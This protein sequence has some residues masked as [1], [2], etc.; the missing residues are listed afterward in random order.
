MSSARPLRTDYSAAVLRRLAKRAKDNSQSRRLLSPN[1]CWPS[2]S[3]GLR[4]GCSRACRPRGIATPRRGI[5][6]HLR[7]LA[8]AALLTMRAESG[9]TAAQ[10]GS[11]SKSRI[12]VTNLRCSGQNRDFSAS[13]LP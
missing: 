3:A 13:E 2:A 1:A 7:G 8:R 10:H 6:A 9:R 12:V 5:V 11:R 4:A